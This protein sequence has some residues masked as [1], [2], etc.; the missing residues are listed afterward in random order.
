MCTVVYT[1]IALSTRPSKR[2]SAGYG[3]LE[4]L[5]FRAVNFEPPL[6]RQLV[7][8][9]GRRRTLKPPCVSCSGFHSNGQH[10]E[11]LQPLQQHFPFCSTCLSEISPAKF[12]KI[13]E[14][15]NESRSANIT[16][17][18]QRFPI[19]DAS[20]PRKC[21][22]SREILLTIDRRIREGGA[23]FVHCHPKR[24]R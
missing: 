13:D 20:V 19:R 5:R 9:T 7:I 23:V 22:S 8:N 11:K 4:R 17:P 18:Y 21:S 14:V 3:D 16:A 12:S 1:F 6:R 10:L 15:S 2:L 24:W